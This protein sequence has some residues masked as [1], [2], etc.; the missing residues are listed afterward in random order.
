MLACRTYWPARPA[1]CQTCWL[2]SSAGLPAVDLTTLLVF[3]PCWPAIPPGLPAQR[4]CQPS[5][6]AASVGLHDLWPARTDG[7]PAFIYNQVADLPELLALQTYYLPS[8]PAFQACWTDEGLPSLVACRS[9]WSAIH[10]GLT[11]LRGCS[12]CCHDRPSG[13]PDLLACEA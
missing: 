4:T 7:L 13:L 11:S 1:A 10:T 12:S 9:C 2:D 6:P 5:C 3:Q 8:L